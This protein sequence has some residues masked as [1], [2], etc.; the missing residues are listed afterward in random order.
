M[1][2]LVSAGYAK[3]RKSLCFKI[4]LGF[5][6]LY[7]IFNT[8]QRFSDIRLVM[9]AD[10]R[11]DGLPAEE[12][13]FVEEYSKNLC[14]DSIL[15]DCAMTML[16]AAAV[17][18]AI[19]IGREYGDGTMRNKL[20]VGHSRSAVY[21]SNLIVCT[22]VNVG[23]ML[24][25]LGTV[26]A[27]GIPLMG[28]NLT[29]QQILLCMVYMI[30]ADIACTALM[31]FGTMLIGNKAAGCVAVMISAFALLLCS[32]YIDERLSVTEYTVGYEIANGKGVVHTTEK[33]K[34]PYYISGT[35]RVIY[36]FLDETMPVSQLY[37]MAAY[38]KVPE[39]A[40]AL[41]MDGVI[42][43]VVTGVGILIYRKKNIK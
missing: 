16:F 38:A 10:M 4:Y 32:I 11:A 42:F 15:F 39:S 21:L 24:L 28:T 30:A 25:A 23:G 1:F 37:H 35:Q 3:L 5:G 14:A 7:S 6:I 27:L 26:S 12:A 19:F 31:V 18:T 40:P 36:E 41:A 33:V 17:F 13:H 2:K 22:T 34:N 20:I 9:N 43:V 8:L 29:A